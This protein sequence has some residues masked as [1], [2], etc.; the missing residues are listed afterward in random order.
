MHMSTAIINIATRQSREIGMNKQAITQAVTFG[1]IV[2]ASLAYSSGAIAG[3]LPTLPS[4]IPSLGQ[5]GA[6]LA[7]AASAASAGGALHAAP[8]AL[9]LP[10]VASPDSLAA[11]PGSGAELP[12]LDQWSGRKQAY[13]G[14]TN[15]IRPIRFPGGGS[16][17]I[18]LPLPLPIP[19]VASGS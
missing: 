7:G 5:T 3:G 10:T 17:S 9:T 19:A 12:G 15:A 1:G 16:I 4:T 8:V 14:K 18:P 2:L 11:I 13:A 6:A